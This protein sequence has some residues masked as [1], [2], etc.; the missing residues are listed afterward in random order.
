M[1]KK[2][3]CEKR[4]VADEGIRDEPGTATKS[5][6]D[7]KALSWLLDEE[8]KSFG[9]GEIEGVECESRCNPVGL[10]RLGARFTKWRHAR[11]HHHQ[12]M[13]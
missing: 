6:P 12:K 3:V 10:F 5:W 8:V 4:S 1:S 9:D 2:R 7:L 11:E 13:I